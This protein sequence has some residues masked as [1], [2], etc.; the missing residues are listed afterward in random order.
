MP[1]YVEVWNIMTF[2]IDIPDPNKQGYPPD[3]VRERLC[4]TM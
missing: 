1:M 3:V 2:N 4:V